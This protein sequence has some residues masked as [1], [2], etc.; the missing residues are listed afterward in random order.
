MKKYVVLLSV[1]IS[2]IYDTRAQERG[3][4]SFKIQSS[5]KSVFDFAL[6]KDYFISALN[7][8]DNF[9]QI[10]K[11]E[12]NDKSF[13]SNGKRLTYNFIISKVNDTAS[14]VNRQIR[15]EDNLYKNYVNFYVDKGIT[16]DT[17]CYTSIINELNLVRSTTGE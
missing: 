10:V 3:R 8:E 2:L 14:V 12:K 13:A 5:E 7:K 9:M 16:N 15:I 4:N 17:L 1:I 6:K 11:L